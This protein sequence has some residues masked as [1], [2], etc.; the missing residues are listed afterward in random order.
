MR[1]LYK[2]RAR[3][4]RRKARIKRADA[5]AIQIKSPQCEEKSENKESGHRGYTNQG[6]TK[7]LRLKRADAEAIQINDAEGRQGRE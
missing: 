7:G 6:P 2:S 4:G 1:R 5:E 3:R